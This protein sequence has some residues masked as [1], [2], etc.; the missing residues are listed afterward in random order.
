MSGAAA[1]SRPRVRRGADVPE[2]ID[3]G[4]VPKSMLDRVEVVEGDMTDPETVRR[5]VRGV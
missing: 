3:W 2:T 5:A 4:R 1:E